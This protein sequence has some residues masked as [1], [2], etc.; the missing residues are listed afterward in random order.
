MKEPKYRGTVPLLRRSVAHYRGALPQGWGSRRHDLSAMTMIRTPFITNEPLM[1]H[2]STG[3]PIEIP[4]FWSSAYPWPAKYLKALHV[5][6]TNWQ[7]Y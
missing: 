4:A 6:E 2:I 7:P 1:L 5:G 3:H